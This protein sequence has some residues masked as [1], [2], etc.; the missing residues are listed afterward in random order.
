MLL[1]RE[2]KVS[3]RGQGLYE[4]TTPIVNAWGDDFPAKGLLHLFL[5]HTSASLIIQENAAPEA[6]GDL[7]R[8]IE[9]LAPQGES[10]HQH[11]DEGPDDS[12]S[13]MRSA[14]TGCSLWVPVNAGALHLGTWQGIFLWEHRE[15]PHQRNVWMTLV[16]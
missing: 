14:I 8:F 16:N 1:N 6:R 2:I 12:P 7:Q 5:R 10:W 9:R 15:Q 3:T 13:H 11:T 4:I